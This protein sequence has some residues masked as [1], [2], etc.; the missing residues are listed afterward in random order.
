MEKT[1][2]HVVVKAYLIPLRQ[3][4]AVVAPLISRVTVF[5][6]R[7]EIFQWFERCKTASEKFDRYSRSYRDLATIER[8]SS[9]CRAYTLD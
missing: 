8:Q 1:K 6:D 5:L 2:H 4:H 9:C 3:S 7:Y